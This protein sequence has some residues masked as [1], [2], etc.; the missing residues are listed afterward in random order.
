[1]EN[2]LPCGNWQIIMT[3]LCYNSKGTFRH[4][5]VELLIEPP[6]NR[7]ALTRQVEIKRQRDILSSEVINSLYDM[8]T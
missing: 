1:M 6:L 4:F 2:R 5:A 7:Q 3:A 8:V